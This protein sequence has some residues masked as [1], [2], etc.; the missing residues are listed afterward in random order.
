MAKIDLTQ[1]GITGVSEIIYNPSYEALFEAETQP[2]L[3]GFDVGKQRAR[4][5]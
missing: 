2:D 4:C 5:C 1:Y 3:E